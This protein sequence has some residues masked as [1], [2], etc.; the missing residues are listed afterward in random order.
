[1]ESWY[2]RRR[3][4]EVSL[5][6]RIESLSDVRYMNIVRSAAFESARSDRTAM[7]ETQSRPQNSRPA[8]Y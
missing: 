2:S 8:R 7:Q 4:L 1:M 3:S 6:L 5:A